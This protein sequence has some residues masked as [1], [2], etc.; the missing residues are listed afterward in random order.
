MSWTYDGKLDP[1]EALRLLDYLSGESGN[2]FAMMIESKGSPIEGESK[3]TYEDG[4]Q[5][6]DIG[7]YSYKSDVVIPPGSSKGKLRNHAFIVIRDCDAATASIASLL[8]SQDSD[9]KV[10]ISVFKA[11][12]D[13]SKD[14]Q[15]HLEF[16]LEGARVN[17][18]AIVTG[19]TPKRP[20]DLIFFDY[21]KLEI[22][23]APQQQT[24]ARGAVR[25]CTFAGN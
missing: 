1:D 7:G 25:T 10:T 24:G 21:T 12:G 13:S 4:K 8:K 9:L 16:V 14:Q 20:C 6:M 19:G 18:H 2:D 5:R 22:R 23:S 17:C 15:S 3:R 11:G